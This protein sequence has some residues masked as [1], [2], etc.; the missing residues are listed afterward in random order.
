MTCLY[1][2]IVRVRPHH[3]LHI[4]FYK[5]CNLISIDANKTSNINRHTLTLLCI[6]CYNFVSIHEKCFEY[7]FTYVCIIVTGHLLHSH[8][9]GINAINVNTTRSITRHIFSI[10]IH[11]LL[12]ICLYQSASN[13]NMYI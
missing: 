7:L 10:A 2:I 13:I 6:V 3:L 11:Y 5:L 12:Y 9:N 8:W 4:H 1:Y